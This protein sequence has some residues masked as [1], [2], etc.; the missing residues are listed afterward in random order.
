MSLFVSGVHSMVF[1]LIACWG[2]GKGSPTN[3]MWCKL[4]FKTIAKIPQKKKQSNF[5]CFCAM[6]WGHSHCL[7]TIAFI[8]RGAGERVHD[9]ALPPRT[10]HKG[11]NGGGGASSKSITCN[12]Q[13]YQDRIETNLLQPFAHTNFRVIF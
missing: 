4:Y 6:Q 7:A 1:F 3:L 10:F 9:E 5:K 8:L 12:F 13:V 11:G 2:N